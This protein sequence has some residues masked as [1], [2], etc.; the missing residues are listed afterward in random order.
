[1]ADGDKNS[2]RSLVAGQVPSLHHEHPSYRWWVLLNV[3][4]GTFMAVL[5]STIVNVSL[6][7]I[8]AT[9]GT[10]V[11]KAE[12]ILTGYLLVFA[13]MLPSSGWIAD[14]YGY[15]KTYILSFILFTFGSFLCGLAWDENALIFFRIVQ[16][17]G[18]GLLMP[19]GMAIILRE[20]PVEQR[21]T[22]LGFWGISA[23]ASVSL[24]PLAGGYLVDNFSWHAIFD[25]NVPVGIV[26]VI[27][28]FLIQREYKT[29]K[30]RSFDVVGF[31]SVTTFLVA[32]LLALSDGNASW[33]DGGWTSPFILSCFAI[34]AAG[35]TVFL[36]TE[37]SI[38]HPLIDLSLFKYFN[39]SM[40]NI[41]LFIFG[42]AIFGSTFLLPLYLQNSLG[43]T[44]TQVGMMFLPAGIVQGIMSPVSGLMGD[45]LNPKV[46]AFLGMIFLCISWYMNTTLSLYS[47]H[48]D[49]MLPLYMRGIGLGLLFTPLSSLAYTNIPKIKMAQA[50]GLFNVIRQIGGSFG[51][52]VIG[53]MM[54]TRTMTHMQINGQVIDSH[55][56]AFQ[57]II[58]GL[59]QFAGQVS[60]GTSQLSALR[61]R[62]ILGS[63]LA[64]QS[65]VQGVDDVFLFS[66]LIIAVGVIPILFLRTDRKSS[67]EKGVSIE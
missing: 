21:G 35:F 66:F 43:Y 28:T 56:P 8:M 44:A 17:A 57:H 4:I 36:I 33:N 60:S 20:F 18:G 55:A 24:G 39:F 26:G 50:S 9:F 42:F 51:V 14:H 54:T 59:Q 29:E 48:G 22:A 5:D 47:S 25:V 3:M 58:N 40:A 2:V 31:L 6:P 23:A 45:K 15:K 34:S 11:D 19:I 41:V 37:F 53:T 16:G 46:P 12:W 27:A 38:E 62:A 63:H 7:K 64:S 13:V 52:A 49:I 1:M 32:I 65:F 67:G 61:A 30:A 10:S